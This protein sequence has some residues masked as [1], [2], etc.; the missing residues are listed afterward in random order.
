M[1]PRIRIRIHTNMSWIRN[2][3]LKF[4]HPL[5]GWVLTSAC[6]MSWSSLMA[7]SRSRLIFTSPPTCTR[8]QYTRHSQPFLYKTIL[9]SIRICNEVRQVDTVW[10]RDQ[11]FRL[12]RPLLFESKNV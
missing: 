10:N 1:D 5:K 3:A 9:H 8:I 2:I 4:N 11:I 6:S 12:R 7:S